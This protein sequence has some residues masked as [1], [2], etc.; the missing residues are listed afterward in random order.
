MK[1]LFFIC[2]LF[3]GLLRCFDCK[4]EDHKET[5][6]IEDTRP[7]L[8]ELFKAIEESKITNKAAFK[9]NLLNTAA[10]AHICPRLLFSLGVDQWDD[11]PEKD[12][13]NQLKILA[14]SVQFLK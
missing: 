9:A 10:E 2:I 3:L 11:I 1:A 7:E 4:A 13:F 5:L 14:T 12:S 6:K 8:L